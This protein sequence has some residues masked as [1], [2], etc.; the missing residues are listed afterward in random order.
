[1][2]INKISITN[3]FIMKKAIFKYPLRLIG[4][5]IIELPQYAKILSVGKQ[6]QQIYLW[7]L[8]NKEATLNEMRD[9]EIYGTGDPVENA[10]GLDFIDTCIVGAFV[11]HIF[12]RT[13]YK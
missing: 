10:E 3:L 6:D 1:M 4:E 13:V 8:I 5:Q 12:E 11:W 2:R 9:I 7:A